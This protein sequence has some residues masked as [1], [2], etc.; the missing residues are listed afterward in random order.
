MLLALLLLPLL[1]RASA[2]AA[3]LLAVLPSWGCWQQWLPVGRAPAPVPPGQLQH[4][5][6]LLAA[7]SLVR[8]RCP[9]GWLAR[10]AKCPALNGAAGAAAVRP[11]LPS[12]A[13]RCANA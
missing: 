3:Q 4:P 5:L 12:V 11:L 13:P 8:Q 2:A 10:A 9:G 6:P 1:W 7:A